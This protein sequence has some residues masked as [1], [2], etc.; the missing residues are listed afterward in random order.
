M[1]C[2]AII[3]NA[4]E[5]KLN[6]DY[7]LIAVFIV[8]IKVF[9]PNV[10]RELANNTI[11][12]DDLLDQASLS[13]LTDDQWVQAGRLEGHFIRWLLKYF[14]SSDKDADAL[15]EQG[16]HLEYSIVQGRSA[17]ADICRCLESFK[18]E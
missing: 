17:I 12:Y 1:T 6:R 14:L 9:I 7:S 2:F 13:G 16:N 3:H 18:N 5:G 15:L 10:Y 11:T 8:V 4:T